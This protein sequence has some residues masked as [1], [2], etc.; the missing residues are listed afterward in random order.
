ISH[1]L[2]VVKAMAHRVIVLKEGA[3]VEQGEALEVIERPRHPYT[4]SLVA[5]AFYPAGSGG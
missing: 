4:Q 2:A 3:V 5:A 1:D